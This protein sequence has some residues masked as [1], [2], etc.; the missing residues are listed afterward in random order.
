V[1]TLPALFAE[2]PD[3]RVIHTH[4]DPTKF[5]ASL[6]SILS[7]LRFMR[8]DA[9]DVAALAGAMEA[10]YTMFLQGTI[11]E[12]VSGVI[13]DDR[14][15]DSHFTDLM[16]DPVGCLRHTYE[17]LALDWPIGHDRAVTE[18]LAH[19]PK[20]KHGAHAYSLPDVGLAP[21]SVRKSFEPY[22]THYG[23]AEE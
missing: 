10:T 20:D 3:A 12:R 23:I 2:Y 1:S 4:R 13:P 15:V 7:A 11:E 19:K 8:S 17:R 9:V 21:D 22:V 16:G 14:I 5:L 18:Y 6:V